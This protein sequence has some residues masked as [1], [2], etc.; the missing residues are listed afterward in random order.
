MNILPVS[1]TWSEVWKSTIVLTRT[2]FS[3]AT[4]A[5]YG[6]EEDADID[7]EDVENNRDG[8]D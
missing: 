1:R 6:L 3:T 7:G 2:K 5:D 4:L 8:E